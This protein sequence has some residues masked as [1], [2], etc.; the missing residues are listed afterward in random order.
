MKVKLFLVLIPSVVLGALVVSPVDARPS[1]ASITRAVELIMDPCNSPAILSPA[2]GPAMVTCESTANGLN[3]FINVP[4][5]YIVDRAPNLSLVSIPTYFRL[6]WDSSSLS[7]IDTSPRIYEYPPG[8]PTDRLIN[9]RVQLRLKPGDISPPDN[10]VVIENV[11]LTAVGLNIFREDDS[12]VEKESMCNPTHNTLLTVS[13]NQ[14]GFST[15]KSKNP[16]MS[17]QSLLGSFPSST[18]SMGD[19]ERYIDWRELIP[20]DVIT[21]SPYASIHGTGTDHGSPAFQISAATSLVVEARVIWDE[22]REKIPREVTVCDW[23]YWDV[24]DFIDWDRWPDPVYCK[25]EVF[26]EWP[27]YCE[28]FSGNCP[29]GN[30]DNWWRPIAEGEVELLRRPD[31]TYAETYDFVSVQSQPLLVAP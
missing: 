19:P 6:I 16:C 10:G 28:P 2:S 18:P 8:A 22:H 17:I 24:Y 23:S 25:I 20:S 3:P 30:P 29:Y 1:P 7:Y 9:L 13:T 15:G 5:P 27:V 11:A 4:V 12:S 31:G 26:V 21:F 14:G